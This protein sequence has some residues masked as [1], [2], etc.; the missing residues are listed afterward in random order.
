MFAVLGFAQRPRL[1]VL[2]GRRP[3]LAIRRLRGTTEYQRAALAASASSPIHAS[4]AG[5]D[6]RDRRPAGA[7][8]T[9]LTIFGRWD[10]GTDPE[11]VFEALVGQGLVPPG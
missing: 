10:L 4:A 5:P 7:G 1:A 2:A 9:S 3:A 8:D 6:A 11:S